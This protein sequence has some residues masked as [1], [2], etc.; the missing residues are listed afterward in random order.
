MAL[1][2]DPVD[3]DG[4]EIHGYANRSAR[5]LHSAARLT[6]HRFARFVV[7]KQ[8]MDPIRNGPQQQCTSTTLNWRTFSSDFRTDLPPR[9]MLRRKRIPRQ[10]IRVIQEGI[11]ALTGRS[12]EEETRLRREILVKVAFDSLAFGLGIHAYG[13]SFAHQRMDGSG[14]MYKGLFGHVGTTCS[15]R[16]TRY[17]LPGVR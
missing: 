9:G 12:A 15:S 16:M 5:S 13:D 3:D 10:R 8:G 1:Y 2:V 4:R 11:H 7:D 6:L 14:T 17:A